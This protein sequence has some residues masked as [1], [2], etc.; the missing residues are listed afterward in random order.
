MGD[1]RTE[2][3]EQA[4]VLSVDWLGLSVR[5][6]NDPVPI[7]G[8]VWREYSATNVW[9]S[10]RV[11]WSKDG[12][13]VLTFLS[14]PRSRLLAPNCGLVEIENEWFYHGGGIDR[15]MSL[16]LGSVWYEILGISR[17][18]LA[19]DFVPTDAQKKIIEG[20]SSGIYYV[21][22]KRNGS[23][24]WSTTCSEKDD[25]GQVKDTQ[26][27]N[28]YWLDRPIPHCQSWGHKTS[29]IKWKLY[30]KSKELLDAGGG[31]FFMKPYIID[32]WREFGLDYKSV[33]RLEVSLH[34]LN[35]YSIY[36]QPITLDVLRTNMDDVF[37]SLYNKRFQ[38]CENQGHKDK[39]NDTRVPF[40]PIGKSS[41]SIEK[42]EPR[43]MNEHNGRITLL[44]HLVTSLEDEHVLLDDIT[45]HGVLEHMERVIRRDNLDNYF[46]A[47]TG[48]KFKDFAEE[49]EENAIGKFDERCEYANYLHM[50]NK[51]SI[52]AERRLDIPSKAA[53]LQVHPNTA[54]ESYDDS[55]TVI[56]TAVGEW[57]KSQQ[58]PYRVQQYTFPLEIKLPPPGKQRRLLP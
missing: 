8:H 29:A 13:R 12:D 3:E 16:F 52:G 37:M 43:S 1:V 14:Q 18:D 31:K 33:W 9:G 30:Y 17:L 19:V 24:F 2:Q 49:I 35:D 57:M 22:G 20:I 11:L 56:P 5:V 44:R 23:G 40:L 10:R 58:R 50:E 51:G 4:V 54:F 39:T 48:K 28:P 38:V 34:H 41:G 36:G 42:R 55:G 53:N 45:R 21:S 47:M 27:L 46:L 7:P 32:K 15:I 25:S 6:L 26:K